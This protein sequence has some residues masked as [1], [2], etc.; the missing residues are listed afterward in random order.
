MEPELKN[1]M[2]ILA[3]KTVGA[4]LVAIAVIAIVMHLTGIMAQ[5]S[6]IH[7][8]WWAKC[9]AIIGLALWET[10][11]IVTKMDQQKLSQRNGIIAIALMS[12]SALTATAFFITGVGKWIFYLSFALFIVGTTISEGSKDNPPVTQ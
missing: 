10:G 6:F 5:A 12:L 2:M 4:I 8:L 1:K 3:L 11:T 7:N 9:A